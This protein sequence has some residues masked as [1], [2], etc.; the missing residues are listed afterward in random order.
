MKEEAKL[1]FNMM[2]SA[3]IHLHDNTTV[4]QLD[5]IGRLLGVC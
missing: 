4:S 1:F 5:A 2:D 3:K